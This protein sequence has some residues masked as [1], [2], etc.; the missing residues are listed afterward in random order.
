MRRRKRKRAIAAWLHAE[1]AVEI[2]AHYV[3]LRIDHDS[4]PDIANR[5]G[6]FGWPVT[7]MFA[8]NGTEILTYRGYID[9]PRF[10][11]MLKAI[12]IDP[13]PIVI[14]TADAAAIPTQHDS[15]LDAATHD[16]LLARYRD[17]YDHKL[18]SL[19]ATQ[20]FLDYDSVEFA[21]VHGQ[22]GDADETAMARQ[23]F[24][25]ARALVDLAWGGV[26]QYSIDGDGLHP[27]VE[28][29]ATLQA[30][31]LRIYAL[32]WAAL[33]SAQDD[34][35]IDSLRGFLDAFLCS[36]DGVFYV[37]QDAEPLH[38]PITGARNDVDAA[39][40][41]ASVQHLPAWCKRVQWWDRAEG[42]L[43]NPDVTYPQ[44]KRAVAFVCTASYCSLPIFDPAQIA[45]FLKKVR[46][47]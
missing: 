37:S 24:D 43:P 1:V 40:L 9:A 44:L 42:A 23:T 21:I 38:L 33:G 2:S 28:K 12:V 19:Q 6:D 8:A 46:R 14:A 15:A 45:L 47:P 32:A 20:K 3:T 34:R 10:L 35:A 13:S 16:E 22:T 39:K 30:S 11:S 5:Y 25:A 29:P 26:Y 7:V 41:F 36:P 4:H 18:G 27:Q 31:Y 17:T